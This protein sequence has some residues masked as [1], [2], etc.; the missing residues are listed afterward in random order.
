MQRILL[1][2]DEEN[3]LKALRRV[4]LRHAH[5]LSDSGLIVDT[6][7]SSPEALDVARHTA[8]HLV[9]SDYRMPE[10]NGVEFLSAL[11]ALQ[12][13]TPR[14]ILSGCADLESLMGAINEAHIFRFIPKPWHDGEV[15][16]A[17]AQALSHNKLLLENQRL[18]DQ[19]RT[20]QHQ[21]RT[22]ETELKRLERECPGITR[23]NWGPDGSI[24]VDLDDF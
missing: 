8:Y 20:Q 23:V 24:I 11:G 12:I 22:Q 2:D 6:F 7:T 14:I 18:A 15:L 16:S 1:V 5:S 21:I 4:L 13:F 9:I 3:I 10:M 19:V 17:V